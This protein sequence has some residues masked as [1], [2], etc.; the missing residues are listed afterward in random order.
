MIYA[1]LHCNVAN[2]YRSSWFGCGCWF[3]PVSKCIIDYTVSTWPE[4]LYP[5]SSGSCHASEGNSSKLYF[6][7]GKYFILRHTKGKDCLSWQ[8]NDNGHCRM[9]HNPKYQ[10]TFMNRR[11]DCNICQCRMARNRVAAGGHQNLRN[12]D[13]LLPP[14]SPAAKLLCMPHA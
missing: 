3:V 12:G 13:A 5:F 14:S 8:R 11:V 6:L 2:G 10:I 9:P 1:N 7:E 4:L